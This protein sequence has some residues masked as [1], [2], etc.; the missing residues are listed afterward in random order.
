MPDGTKTRG[1][2]AEQLRDLGFERDDA[3]DRRRSTSSPTSAA[4]IAAR[5]PAVGRVTVSLRKSVAMGLLAGSRRQLSR[6][7]CGN[8]ITSRIDGESVS[9]ITSR[10][11]PMPSP[12]V[13]GRPYSIARM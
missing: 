6:F 1:L 5:I 11:M 4:A 12:A 8:R 13:G 10:S 9:S 3:S 7:S 2:E